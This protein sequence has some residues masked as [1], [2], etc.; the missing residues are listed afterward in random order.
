MKPYTFLG[1]TFTDD[2][3]FRKE[4]PP[5]F[6]HLALVKKGCDTPQK[7]EQALYDKRKKAKR[8]GKKIPY[9]INRKAA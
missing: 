6:C 5:Y 7:V 8:K 3:D 1:Q 4:F 2:A 9:S